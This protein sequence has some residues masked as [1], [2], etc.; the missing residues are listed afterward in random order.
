MIGF[1]NIRILMIN[2]FKDYSKENLIKLLRLIILFKAIS[3]VTTKLII[4]IKEKIKENSVLD[5]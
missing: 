4:L 1:F 2:I 5:A 3:I